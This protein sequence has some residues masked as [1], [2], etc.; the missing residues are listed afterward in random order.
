MESVH[1]ADASDSIPSAPTA[2]GAITARD[3][4]AGGLAISAVVSTISS[5]IPAGAQIEES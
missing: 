4:S 2:A 1:S 3:G 5:P